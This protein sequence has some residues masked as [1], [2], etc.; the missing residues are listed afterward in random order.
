MIKY[1][2]HVNRKTKSSMLAEHMMEMNH[3]STIEL[4]THL[5]I[6]LFFLKNNDN[7][8]YIQSMII[9]PV[10]YETPLANTNCTPSLTFP[11]LLIKTIFVPVF[12]LL[13]WMI[14]HLCFQDIK[15]FL[16]NYSYLRL[17]AETPNQLI[18]YEI[19]VYFDWN[20]TQRRFEFS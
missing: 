11:S 3:R 17:R 7:Q 1:R 13:T 18:I 9:I 15:T 4:M 19:T 16:V 10:V 8:I 6:N 5:S 12:W 14:K 2:P 20:T